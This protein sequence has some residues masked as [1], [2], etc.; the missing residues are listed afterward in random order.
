MTAGS[1]T[2][3]RAVEGDALP[4]A[5]AEALDGGRPV[6]PLPPEPAE[7]ARAVRALRLDEPADPDAAVVVLSSG[8]TGEPK[9]VVLSAAALRAGA[10]ATHVRL[11]GVGHWL[12]PLPR[13][14][15]AGLM[16]LA[17]AHLSGSAV[18]PLSG[19]LAEL[20]DL[21]LPS[22]RRYLSLVPTQLV[23]ALALPR[24]VEALASL[25][26]VLVGGAATD[27]AL[28]ARAR[29][30]GVPCVTT[31][32]MSETCGGCVYDGVPLDGVDVAVGLPDRVG[33]VDG[34][35]IS[36]GGPVVFSGYRGR[37]DLTADA[38][39][40]GRFLTS[41]RGAWVTGTDGVARLAVLGR[42][43]D[44]VVSGGHNVDLSAVEAR[45][46]AWPERGTAEIAVVGVPDPEWG[47]EV[48]AVTD[49]HDLTLAGL[50]S[51]VRAEL[52]AYAAPRRLVALDRLPRTGGDKVDRR[53]LRAELAPTKENR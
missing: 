18:V 16:V 34:D 44:V 50:R 30:A 38:L 41:D 25:D 27:P 13:H 20:P 43:D 48:V 12:L 1:T 42:V 49:D 31:Y 52:P 24:L 35:R 28:L 15:V 19:D 10:E 53:R 37:P 29:V 21:A 22:G 14:H 9:G 39:R 26:A 32:G 40:S 36:V 5:L 7:R 47:T 23:R 3:L 8:S 2:L 17:R 6:A 11:G 4:A 51:W 33:G 46:H 45:A